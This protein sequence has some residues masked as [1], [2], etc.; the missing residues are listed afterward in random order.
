MQKCKFC[1]FFRWPWGLISIRADLFLGDTAARLQWLHHMIVWT[2]L[3]SYYFYLGCFF[4][5][6]DRQYSDCLIPYSPLHPDLSI[7][8]NPLRPI[9]STSMEML[10]PAFSILCISYTLLQSIFKVFCF[11]YSLHVGGNG[12]YTGVTWL[13]LWGHCFAGQNL[14]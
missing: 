12:S 6:F 4:Y 5:I 8:F 14:D 11:F 1:L 13:F 2:S 7:I 3:T 10:S 9:K